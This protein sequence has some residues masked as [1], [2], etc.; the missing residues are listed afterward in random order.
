ML[1]YEKQVLGFYVTSNPLSH[2]A[3]TI[4][5]Y[6]TVNTSQLNETSQEKSIVIGGMVTKK[7]YHI[8]KR[9]KNAGSKM[10]VFILEDLQSQVEVVLFP[11]TLAKYGDYLGEDKVVFVKGKVD[12]R[13]E[14]P[15]IIAA[16]LIDLDEAAEKLA[17]RV[18]IELKAEEV[19]K[20]KIATIKSICAKHKGK[21][22]LYIAVQTDKGRVYANAD[23]SLSVNPDTDFCRQMKQLVGHENFQ[24]G[25]LS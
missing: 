2:C 17:S 14:K 12:Y 23:K 7:R 20:E 11:D 18:R 4:N 24:L 5:V 13:R 22:P 6:S 1:A 19:T 25:R 21:S 10:A 3:E 9:G 8:T 15:N 16:E